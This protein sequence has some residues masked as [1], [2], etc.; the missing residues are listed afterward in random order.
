MLAARLGLVLPRTCISFIYE[1]I[2]EAG[3]EKVVDIVRSVGNGAGC[4]VNRNGVSPSSLS[5]R[6]L[7]S[8]RPGGAGVC[9]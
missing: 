9:L 1:S 8:G 3:A 7:S 4:S 2:G 6:V 5:F